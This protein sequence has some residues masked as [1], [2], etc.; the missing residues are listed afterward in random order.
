MAEWTGAQIT[1][2]ISAVGSFIG[3]IFFWKDKR[4]RRIMQSSAESND[5]W[6]A[7]AQERQEMADYYK[8]QLEECLEEK[9][10]K[11]S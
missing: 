10:R 3:I 4:E 5:Q 8:E 11:E 9:Q 7:I 1:A 6:K 2:L